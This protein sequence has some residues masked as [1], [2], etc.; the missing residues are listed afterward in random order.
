[1]NLSKNSLS[2]IKDSLTNSVTSGGHDKKEA[3]RVNDI[4]LDMGQS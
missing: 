1:M 3:V 4:G 2:T